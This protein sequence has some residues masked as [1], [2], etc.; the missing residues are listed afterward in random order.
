MVFCLFI[1]YG[2]GGM[3]IFCLW[4]GYLFVCGIVKLYEKDREFCMV[5]GGF[6]LKYFV[7][8][9]DEMF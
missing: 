9:V 3:F 2:L 6:I 8:L 5:L 4:N 1:E 7:I